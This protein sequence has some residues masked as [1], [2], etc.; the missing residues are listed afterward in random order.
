MIRKHTRRAA[1][2]AFAISLAVAIVIGLYAA[3][4]TRPA[5]ATTQAVTIKI[6]TKNFP[7]EY[8]LGQ[9][10][11]QALE[12]KGFKISY[13]ENIGATELMTTAL[14]SKKIDFYPEYTGVIVQD[15]FHHKTS[16]KT[17]SAT[18]KLAKKLEAT[19]GFSLLKPTPFYDTDVLAVTNATAKKYGLKSIGDLKKAGA[20]KL[21][22]FPECKTR[23]T[24]FL[25]YTKQYGLS[26]ASFLPLAGISAYAA[27]DAGKVLAADVFSTDPPLGKNSKYTVLKDPKHVTG[28]QNVAPIVRTSVAKAAGPAFTKTVNAVSA[29]LTLPAI[30]AM[31]KAVEVDKQ[32]AAS[33]ASAFLKANGLK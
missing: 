6:G 4:F 27:L 22:G 5:H 1:K 16:P 23:N 10:Y 8:I 3:A 33:V 24:C 25:G 11:K 15:V 21:G 29:K 28:F 7:E 2:A 9:L 13:K 18:Y 26:Q 32:S 30:V 31:N 17:A 20:F 19:K 12:A 14:Q